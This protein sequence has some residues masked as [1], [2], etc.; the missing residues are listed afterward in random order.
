MHTAGLHISNQPMCNP[1]AP[2]HWLLL[3]SHTCCLSGAASSCL[4]PALLL[5]AVLLNAVLVSAVL[6]G[7]PQSPI[8]AAPGPRSSVRHRPCGWALPPPLYALLTSSSS[9]RSNWKVPSPLP[10]R[11][12]WDTYSDTF[13]T[14]STCSFSSSP[15]TKSAMLA[16]PFLSATSCSSRSL[17]KLSFS[18]LS[19]N[20]M[21][22]SASPFSGWLNSISGITILF[23]FTRPPRLFW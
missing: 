19:A 12:S 8:C 5:S 23:N 10:T 11:R 22:Y 6:L 20:S 9:S 21:A 13:F 18:R 16:S 4:E 2:A 17:V 15:S 3:L 1:C 14:A 7:D